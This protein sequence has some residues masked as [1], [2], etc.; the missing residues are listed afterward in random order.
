MI[1]PNHKGALNNLGVIRFQAGDCKQARMFF[2]QALTQA[3]YDAKTYYLLAKTFLAES[4]R[5]AETFRRERLLW[6]TSNRHP[7]HHEDPLPLALC[8]TS[9]GRRPLAL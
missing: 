8:R 6:V 2:A 1:D 3:P 9:C 4:N 5:P 7:T